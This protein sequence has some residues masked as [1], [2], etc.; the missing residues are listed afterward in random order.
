MRE[1]AFQTRRSATVMLIIANVVAFL[2]E[3]VVWGYHPRFNYQN[4]SA[5]FALSWD[6]LSHGY[7][8]QLITFQFLHIGL[9][10]LL[11][12]CLVIFFFGRELEQ[13]LGVK[14]FLT[15]YFGSGVIGGLVQALAGGIATQFRETPWS[16]QFLGPVVGASAGGMGLIAAFATLYPDRLLTLLVFFVVPV[17]I[18]ARFLLLFTALVAAFFIIFPVQN[19]ANAA[20]LGGIAAG[21]FYIRYAVHWDWHWPRLRRRGNQPPRRLVR[22]ST[23]SSAAW[24]R[25]RG[26]SEEEIPAEEFLSKEVDP[27]LDKISAHGIQSLTERERRILQSARDRIKIR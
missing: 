26:Y 3:C 8:W 20:H 19:F 9:L 21:I 23:G 6:G 2:I 24:G 18:R 1:P 14:K 15:L 22:V 27:I 17:N 4:Y 5:Y 10:H 16:M 7:V 12:N 11:G 25:N 13:V